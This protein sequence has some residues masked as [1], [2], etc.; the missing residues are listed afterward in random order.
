MNNNFR[1]STDFLNTA[2]Y[3]EVESGGTLTMNGKSYARI[4]PKSFKLVDAAGN[5][6][7]WADASK[8]SN[9][10]IYQATFDISAI[11]LAN[12]SGGINKE[13]AKI[14]IRIGLDELADGNIGTEPATESMN[15]LGVYTLRLFDLE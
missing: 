10:K 11:T 3:V 4:T 2:Y 14:Y 6:I 9:Y 8:L 5:K 12:G 15:P 13:N 7:D 1:T